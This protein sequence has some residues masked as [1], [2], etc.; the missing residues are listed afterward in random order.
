MEP[1]ENAEVKQQNPGQFKNEDEKIGQRAVTVR[2]YLK[3]GYQRSEICARMQITQGQYAYTLK[4]MTRG[5]KTNNS[6]AFAAY[7]LGE[8][9]RLDEIEL[10]MKAARDRTDLRAVASLHKVAAEVRRGIMDMALKLG[11]L[12]RETIRI[13][14]RRVDVCFGD[15]EIVPWFAVEEQKKPEL[16]VTKE[17]GKPN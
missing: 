15:E 9:A 10:D 4:W 5:F 6:E 2:H 13:E 3:R 8:Q 16:T 1:T 12:Q 7:M 17:C 14:A 11:V